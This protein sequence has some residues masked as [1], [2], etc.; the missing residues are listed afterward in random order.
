MAVAIVAT[1]AG[2]IAS[3][4]GFG[5]GSI[6]T[7]V[8][9][10]QI[11]TK[12]AI[13]LVS[14]PHFIATA[15]RCWSLRKDIDKK[16]LFSF[17]ITSA[18]GGLAGAALYSWLVSPPLTMV[19]G[20]IL[21]FA[22]ITGVTRLNERLRF[23]GIV[24]WIAGLASGALG[25][26]VGNQGGIR[27]AALLGFELDKNAFVATATAIGLVVDCA[28]MPVYLFL[29]WNEVERN[30]LIVL[31]ASIGVSIGTI[32]GMRFLKKIDER[33]FKRI[34]SLVIIFLGIWMLYQALK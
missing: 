21:I 26:L 10:L 30:W 18:A 32:V 20:V 9:S 22:G 33:S 2:A 4:A 27:S 7:P 14:I 5:I 23:R 19:F 15:I 1:V 6:L 12:I 28:R 31:V 29:Q 24:A 34:V 13:A 11:D 16:V 3:L 17:G 25:G 8:L